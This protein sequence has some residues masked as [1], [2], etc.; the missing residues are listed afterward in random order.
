[1]SFASFREKLSN[2][3]NN[4]RDLVVTGTRNIAAC[5]DP[6]LLVTYFDSNNNQIDPPIGTVPPTTINGV[7]WEHKLEPP[8]DVGLAH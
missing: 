4:P 1:M 7:E 3:H 2:T 8:S 5:Q 6:N